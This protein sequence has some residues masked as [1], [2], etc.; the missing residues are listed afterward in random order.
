MA[1]TVGADG[2]IKVKSAYSMDETIARIKDDISK[3]GIMFFSAVDQQQLAAKA[4]IELPPSTLLMFGNP[5]LGSQFIT[6][7]GEAGLDWPVRLL[8]QQDDQGQRVC[9][10]HRLRL[11]REASR[12]HQP[13]R[14][15]H[16]GVRR[17]NV[18]HVHHQG[19]V[20]E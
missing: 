10:L 11:H 4:G 20:D 6:A 3:K 9:D 16:D 19:T 2:V 13:R 17:G 14:A 8:V 7:K 5:A 1:Q 15:V 12:H 18:D